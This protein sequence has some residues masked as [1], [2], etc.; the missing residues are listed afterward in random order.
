MDISKLYQLYLNSTGV[1]TDTRTLKKGQLYFALTGENFNGNL[2]A[3][4]ALDNGASAA[5]VDDK[6]LAGDAFFQ[7]SSSLEALQALARY[8]RAKLKYPIIGLTGSNGKTTSKELLV[9]VLKQKFRVGFTKG[10]F[11]N[12]IGVPLTL[13]SFSKNLEMGVV[14]MGA[15]HQKEIAFLCG[16]SQPDFGFITNYGKAHLEGFGGVEGIIKGKSELYDYLREADK[17]AVVNQA[18]V[19]QMEKSAGIK[20]FTFGDDPNADYPIE[21]LGLN[22]AGCVKV[23]FN[24]LAVQSNLTG[25]YNFSNVAVAIALGEY[26]K[27]ANADIAQGIENYHPDNNRSQLA[28]TNYN[29]LIKDYYNANPSSMEAAIENFQLLKAANKW[30]I[31]A[32][33]FELGEDA[34]KEHQAIATLC[35]EQ[36][37]EQVILVGENFALCHGSHISLSTTA[38]LVKWLKENRPR[39]KSILLKG[40]RGMALEKALDF[41]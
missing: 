24:A 15:N 1:T 26:F 20:R 13:L 4:K 19:L 40:S 37:F 28:K 39:G 38:D 16:I 10:N 8:H 11:N 36:D 31:L 12:H 5:V 22:D 23:S 21:P 32:D 6:T 14:E 27:I 3:Q 17:T 35:Q 33:M 41:L 9:A 25:A 30:A 18:D 7:V 34:P 2:Y 29:S